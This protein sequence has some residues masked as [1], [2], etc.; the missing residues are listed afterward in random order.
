MGS[1][2]NW[3]G[4]HVLAH[5]ALHKWFRQKDRPVPAFVI[6]DQPSQAHYP[7]ERD[8]GGPDKDRTAVL[9][10]FELISVAAQE[11]APNMQIIVTDHADLNR[12]WFEEAVVERW[13]DGNKLIPETWIT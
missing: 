8:A 13:R 5:L 12:S 11:M 6:F 9:Q 1:G 3:V 10:I 2:E 7:S 4:Y